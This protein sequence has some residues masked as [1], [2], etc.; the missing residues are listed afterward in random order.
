MLQKKFIL[1]INIRNRELYMD[2]KRVLR[3]LKELRLIKKSKSGILKVIFGR[4]GISAIFILLQ[5]FFY[6]NMFNLLKTSFPIL[7]SANVFIQIIFIIVIV[8]SN[9]SSSVQLSWLILIA[10][11]PLYAI[12]MYYFIKNDIGNRKLKKYTVEYIE[13]S[14]NIIKP[15]FQIVEE[16]KEKNPRLFHLAEYINKTGCYPIYRNQGIKYY[17]I[18]E[19]MFLDILK[20]IKKAKKFIFLEYFIIDEGKMWGSILNVLSDKVKE[21]V[22][23]RVLYDGM[24]EFSLL[25]HHYPDELKKLGIQT[26]IFSKILPFV[27]TSYNYRDHRKLLIVDGKTAF[28]GG[29]NL[30]DE[31]INEIQRFGHWKDAG[32]KIEGNSVQSCILL[33]LQN[34]YLSIERKERRKIERNKNL[35]EELDDKFIEECFYYIRGEAEKKKEK[36]GYLIPYADNPLDGEKVGEMVYIDIINRA[37]KYV[38]IMTPY[39]ILDEA[40]NTTLTHAAKKGIDIRIITPH[41]PD[42]KVVFA[43][44]RSHYKE[45]IEA[46]VGIYEYEPGFVHSKV[47]MSDD[48]RA[49]VGSINLDYRSLYHNF[50]NAIYVEDFSFA[51]EVK[52][53][54]NRTFMKCIK[55]DRKFLYYDSVFNQ[56]LGTL[57]KPFSYLM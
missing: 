10:I 5:F 41:I 8:N 28:T 11:L 57:I 40:L 17:P 12:P 4:T 31:Y 2:D 15:N 7:F 38:Y 37:E 54:F 23:V 32:I 19:D 42:K 29:V 47:F 6:L 51:K 39:L 20:E 30:A 22:E 50:E 27:S 52:E 16:V 33:F 24:C 48:K 44:T 55:I 43:N 46:G 35:K 49:V 36:E 26:R 1:F 3:E 25:P 21:G 14:M 45:L 13:K 9:E 18:G 56:V 34:W 53:D